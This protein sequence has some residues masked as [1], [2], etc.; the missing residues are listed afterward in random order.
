MG[1]APVRLVPEGGCDAS[2]A[3]TPPGGRSL[4]YRGTGTRADLNNHANQMKLGLRNP[5]NWRYWSSRGMSPPWRSTPSGGDGYAPYLPTSRGYAA[6][7]PSS[8]GGGD[9][10]SFREG[11]G[12]GGARMCKDKKLDELREIKALLSKMAASDPDS[13]GACGEL[14]LCGGGGG[15]GAFSDAVVNLT[16]GRRYALEV[17]L[18]GFP[19]SPRGGATRLVQLS[20]G[21]ADNVVLAEAPGGFGAMAVDEEGPGW[22]E[23][24]RMALLLVESL[25]RRVGRPEMICNISSSLSQVIAQVLSGLSRALTVKLL[26]PVSMT[27]RGGAMETCTE[28]AERNA[29]QRLLMVPDAY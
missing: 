5:N 20:D 22:D 10:S 12:H 19:G 28:T 8:E 16:A 11:D 3:A 4:R 26:D 9:A 24:W 7:P 14:W 21:G 18:G 17:G 2:A 15:G 13:V 1:G 29:S 25:G 27:G 23:E 6:R